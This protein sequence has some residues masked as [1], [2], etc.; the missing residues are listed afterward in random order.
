M[1]HVGTILEAQVMTLDKGG[2]SHDEG[3]QTSG[4]TQNVYH[5]IRFSSY[6]D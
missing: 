4:S 3:K 2:G 5:F 1:W 6:D